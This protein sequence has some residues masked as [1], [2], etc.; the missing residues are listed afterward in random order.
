MVSMVSRLFV[1]S[2]F[3]LRLIK[4]NLKKRL[5]IF[6]LF[7]VVITSGLVGVALIE[8][9]F[10]NQIGQLEYELDSIR[11]TVQESDV[12]KVSL[13]LALT[14]ASRSNLSLYLVDNEGEIYILEDKSG[15]TNQVQEIQR[16]S[17]W[18]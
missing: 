13:A 3:N 10:K 14:G 12:D 2:V 15:N 11:S 9:G 8:I 17:C 4:L 1:V 16:S 7:I 18:S 5:T 6:T